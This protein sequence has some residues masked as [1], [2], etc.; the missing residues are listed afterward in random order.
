MTLRSNIL[1]WEKEEIAWVA[2]EKKPSG[3]I[4]EKASAIYKLQREGSMNGQAWILRIPCFHNLS[5][6]QRISHYI[7]IGHLS[8]TQRI[9]AKIL[10]LSTLFYH[11]KILCLK[12]YLLIT[13]AAHSQRVRKK[14]ATTWLIHH[15]FPIWIATRHLMGRK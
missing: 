11:M 13:W 12:A 15:Q 3:L 4:L 14:K 5:K 8:K 2:H 6:K 7:F 1:K 9:Q 10:L